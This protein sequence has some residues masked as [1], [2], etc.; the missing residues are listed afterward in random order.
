MS[1]G[2]RIGSGK[3]TISG[4]LSTV[5]GITILKSVEMSGPQLS[6]LLP[7]IVGQIVGKM[8]TH[9]LHRDTVRIME[10]NEASGVCFASAL[11]FGVQVRKECL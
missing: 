11:S 8:R 4:K 1:T 6:D 9:F 5:K 10:R 7:T 3:N 2:F